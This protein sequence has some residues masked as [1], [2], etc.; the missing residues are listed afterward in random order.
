MKLRI[1]IPKGQLAGGD[2]TAIRSGRASG[3]HQWAV[4]FC[5]HSGSG[6]RLHVDPGSGDGSI[7]GTWRH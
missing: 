3:I 4:V 2:A 7:C 5:Q 1:G 6:D